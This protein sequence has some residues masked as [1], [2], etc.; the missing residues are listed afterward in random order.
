MAPGSSIAI[1]SNPTGIAGLTGEPTVW[2]SGGASVTPIDVA[3]RQVGTPIP[4]GTTA[5]ALALAPGGSGAWVCGGNG[6]LV[7][8]DLTTHRVVSTV[9]VGN[10]PSAV[11]IA[12]GR[13]S[14]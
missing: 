2:V 5:Q 10:Q 6:T 1:G 12:P 11:A 9:H 13:P 8:V 14:S 3:T 4:I 7:H